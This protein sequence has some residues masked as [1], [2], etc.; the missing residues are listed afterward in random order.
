MIAKWLMKD[1]LRAFAL[2]NRQRAM[3]AIRLL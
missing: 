3:S 1:A 2:S